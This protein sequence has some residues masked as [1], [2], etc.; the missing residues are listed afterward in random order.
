MV[1]RARLAAAVSELD[2]VLSRIEE[3]DMWAHEEVVEELMRHGPVLPMRLGTVLADERALDA[4]LDEGADDL[5]SG[6]ARVR[7]AV[8][9]AVRAVIDNGEADRSQQQDQPTGAEYMLGR[10]AAQRRSDELARR[11][12]EPLASLARESAFSGGRSGDLQ[13]RGAYL[14]DEGRVDGFRARVEELEREGIASALVCTGPWPPYSF[15][16]VRSGS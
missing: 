10:L 3:G 7:G 11:V 8:E 13:M 14:V 16:D 15:S 9:L 5:V 1:R 6:L 12:H 2:P 4:V